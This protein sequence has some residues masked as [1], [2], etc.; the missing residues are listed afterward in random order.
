LPEKDMVGG[1]LREFYRKKHDNVKLWLRTGVTLE[2]SIE[3]AK[4][5]LMGDSESLCS[6]TP[7][8]RMQV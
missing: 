1:M 7:Q 8:Q 3:Q 5:L 2:V 6:V 4:A